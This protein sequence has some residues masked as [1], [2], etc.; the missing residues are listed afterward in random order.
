MSNPQP[1]FEQDPL[2]RTLRTPT[3]QAEAVV[4]PPVISS[5]LSGWDSL[6]VELY[7]LQ[8]DELNFLPLANHL[9]TLNL[10]HQG[11]LVRKQDGQ[12]QEALMTTGSMTL[13]PG[14]QSRH[15]RWEHEADILL[16]QLDPQFMRQVAA[17]SGLNESR[18][19]IVNSFGFH[20]PFVQHIGLSLLTEAKSCGLLGPLYVESLTNLLTIHL[21]RNYSTF[22]QT[23]PQVV[24]RLSP[25]RLK[26]VTE[27]IHDNLGQKLTLS[28]LARIANLSPYHFARL[29]RQEIGLSPHQYVVRCRV[30]QA[31]RLLTAG[32]DILIGE[33]A[34]R[35]GFADQSHFTR[36]FK[37]LVG[38]TPKAIL[39]NSKNVPD[40]RTKLQDGGSD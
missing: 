6:T 20:D 24:G 8:P 17:V 15:W 4:N 1:L 29:F 5:K 30:D 34:H 23:V 22:P 12:V 26:Q 32:G 19:E 27:Y 9:I 13:T 7:R 11:N 21:V 31:K 28:D 14:G 16:I 10:G 18:I 2:S 39:Q 36:H 3:A 38:V 35:V 40:N 37:R 25:S 33:V